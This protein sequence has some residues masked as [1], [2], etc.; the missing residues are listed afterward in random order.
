MGSGQNPIRPNQG[1]STTRLSAK[2]LQYQ[3]L[4]GNLCRGGRVSVDNGVNWA[5][6]RREDFLNKI[7]IWNNY[8]KSV[9]L[10]KKNLI[11]LL[12]LCCLQNE[13]QVLAGERRILLRLSFW[14]KQI[15]FFVK[16]YELRAPYYCCEMFLV[17]FGGQ[18]Y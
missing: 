15:S 9:K 12:L 10:K 3:R 2:Q 8:L 13:R 1:S 11:I 18:A 17:G 6:F 16:R 14:E 4:V 5:S 7:Y